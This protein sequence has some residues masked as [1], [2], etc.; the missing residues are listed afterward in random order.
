MQ[1]QMLV[2][3]LFSGYIAVLCIL[4]LAHVLSSTMQLSGMSGTSVTAILS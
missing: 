4:Q 1:M 3:F 2:F